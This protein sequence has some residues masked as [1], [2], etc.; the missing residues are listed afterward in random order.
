M[1]F[2]KILIKPP[3]VR[4]LEELSILFRVMKLSLMVSLLTPLIKIP[5]LLK[6]LGGNSVIN[7]KRDEVDKVINNIQ[8]ASSMIPP[9]L[10]RRC[11]TR[12]LILYGL[13]RKIG[14]RVEV[15]FGIQKTSGGLIGHSWLTYGGLPL[16]EN[17]RHLKE[18]Y[19]IYSSR[20]VK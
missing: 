18:F 8:H 20:V 10:R 11:I 9:I 5:T 2:I 4:S 3:K 12:S 19:V 1:R 13:S 6:L 16:F 14:V 7:M 17:P 15:N